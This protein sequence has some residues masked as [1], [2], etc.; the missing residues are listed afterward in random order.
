MFDRDPPLADDRFEGNSHTG[1]AAA[2]FGFFVGFAGVAL[3]GP[4]S[5]R[6]EGAMGLSGLLVGLLVAAPQLAGSLLRIP[7]GAWVDQ[8]G[9]RNRFSS[10]WDSRSSGWPD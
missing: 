1:L 10:Y 7:F 9:G 6:F 5:A 2:T 8:G 4:V 3:I